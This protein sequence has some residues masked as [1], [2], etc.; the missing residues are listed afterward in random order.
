MHAGGAKYHDYGATH[1]CLPNVIDALYAIKYAIFDKGICTKS[2]L[3]EA[4]QSDF[5]GYE[6]L[7]HKL[8]NIP[9]YGEDNGEVDEFAKKV[10]E[11]SAKEKE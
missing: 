7:Q 9:K 1:L 5:I 8:K 11:E 4:M 2:E 10:M 3:I 6:S